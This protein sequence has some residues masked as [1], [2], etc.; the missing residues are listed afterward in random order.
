NDKAD[1]IHGL[2][3]GNNNINKQIKKIEPHRQLV[4]NI[5]VEKERL[6][7]ELYGYVNIEVN[8]QDTA[9]SELHIDDRITVI[10]M[11]DRNGNNIANLL[12]EDDMNLDK[13]EGRIKVEPSNEEGKLSDSYVSHISID[14][15]DENIQFD[16]FNK[17]GSL[18]ALIET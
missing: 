6:L 7:D 12:N 16:D 11:V 3:D 18:S 9:E 17:T 10:N 14:G 13:I 15:H 5:Y 1:K 8:Y 2:L 4:N